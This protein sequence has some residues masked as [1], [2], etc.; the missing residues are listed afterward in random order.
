MKNNVLFTTYKY[1]YEIRIKKTDVVNPHAFSTIENQ[2][3]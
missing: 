1:I 2:Q 3:I